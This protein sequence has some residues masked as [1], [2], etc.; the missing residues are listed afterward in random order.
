[1]NHAREDEP[2][3]VGRKI[4][5]EDEPATV[6]RPD[7]EEARKKGLRRLG[8][9]NEPPTK[10]SRADEPDSTLE[11]GGRGTAAVLDKN[12]CPSGCP[13]KLGEAQARIMMAI[14][15]SL[16]AKAERARAGAEVSGMETIDMIMVLGGILMAIGAAVVARWTVKAASSVMKKLWVEPRVDQDDSGVKPARKEIDEV[17]DQWSRSWSQQ[18]GLERRK[19]TSMKLIVDGMEVEIKKQSQG[20][21]KV[22]GAAGS[23]ESAGSGSGAAGSSDGAHVGSMEVDGNAE[24][25]ALRGR[26]SKEK[27][28]CNTEWNQFQHD[29]A[30]RGWSMKTMR[31]RYYERKNL[32]KTGSFCNIGR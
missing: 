22:S 7:G 26:I 6:G 24:A 5:R 17:E 2:A 16:V 9:E 30:G 28:V 4:A 32:D 3:T 19:P 18:K 10:K 20:L 15:A 25:G 29:T 23:M 14:G 11:D 8:R 21:E 31:A 1:M 27:K 12:H 13:P